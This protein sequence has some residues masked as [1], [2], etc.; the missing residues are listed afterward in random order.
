MKTGKIR[1]TSTFPPSRRIRGQELNISLFD[2]DGN[3]MRLPARNLSL[4][5]TGRKEYVTAIMD[6]DVSELDVELPGIN[7]NIRTEVTKL[8]AEVDALRRFGNKDCTAMA[9]E[10]LENGESDDDSDGQ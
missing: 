9:D 5:S 10:F 3:E 8:R 1:I 2:I 4:S 7:V 6:L